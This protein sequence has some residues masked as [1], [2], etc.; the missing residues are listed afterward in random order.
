MELTDEEIE[1]LYE[2]L[3]GAVVYD[4]LGIFNGEDKQTLDGIYSKVRGEAKKRKFWWAR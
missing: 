3:T 2:L 1:V 4:N